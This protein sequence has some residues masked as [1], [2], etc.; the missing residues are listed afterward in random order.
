[1]AKIIHTVKGLGGTL[2]HYDERGNFIGQSVPTLFGEGYNTFAAD[3]SYA[4]SSV[5]SVFGDAMV[6]IGADGSYMGSTTKGLF[7]GDVTFGSD[8]DVIG[9][10]GD[11]MFDDGD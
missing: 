3:G 10:F 11:S 1:M 2:M 6:H 8:G 5:R 9:H 7:G 4:G